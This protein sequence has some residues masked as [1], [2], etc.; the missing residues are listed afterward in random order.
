M[1]MDRTLARTIAKF[2]TVIVLAASVGCRT[3]ETP[4]NQVTDAKIT[5]DVKA[6]LV[7]GLGASTVTNI[8]VNSTNGV[9][10]LSGIVHNSTEQAKAIEIAKGVSNVVRVNDSLQVSGGS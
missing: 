6:K 3:N 9:V 10:T 4:E 2:A 7:E 8:S 1:N 5:T